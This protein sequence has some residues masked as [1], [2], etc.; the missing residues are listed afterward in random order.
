MPD[1]PEVIGAHIDDFMRQT[2]AE[3][4]GQLSIEPVLVNGLVAKMMAE[5]DRLKV[6]RLLPACDCSF[7]FMGCSVSLRLTT[8]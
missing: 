4:K 3:M 1:C 2:A 5:A 7:E 6:D 8:A